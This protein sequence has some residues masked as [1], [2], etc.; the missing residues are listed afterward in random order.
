MSGRIY[1][2]DRC[3]HCGRRIQQRSA[4]QNAAFHAICGELAEQLDWPAGSGN[5]IDK[6]AWKRLL[7]AAGERAAGRRAELYP[8]LDGQGFDIVYRRTSRLPK[9]DQSELIEFAKAYGAERGAVFREPPT[10]EDPEWKPQAR[11]Q[12]SR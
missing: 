10:E 11:Q 1:L 12:R 7:V 4:E 3:P 5:M 2:V 8:A 6:E 9:Q